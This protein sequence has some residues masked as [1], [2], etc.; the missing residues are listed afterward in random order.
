[1][2]SEKMKKVAICRAD[3][4]PSTKSLYGNKKGVVFGRNQRKTEKISSGKTE[5]FFWKIWISLRESKNKFEYHMNVFWH[6]LANV[7][8][9]VGGIKRYKIECSGNNFKSDLKSWFVLY[10]QKIQKIAWQTLSI[11]L[12][13]ST[14]SRE[15]QRRSLKTIQWI[16]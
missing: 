6:I 9:F 1:M 16:K 2:Q 3:T 13:L 8:V 10:S 12:Y 7:R 14:L 15:R 4:L 5:F 11:L